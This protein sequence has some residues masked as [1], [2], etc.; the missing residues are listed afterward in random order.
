[1]NHKE[2]ITGSIRYYKVLMAD[3][4]DDMIDKS[5][6]TSAIYIKKTTDEVWGCLPFETKNIP[7]SMLSYTAMNRAAWETEYASGWEL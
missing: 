4:T 3:I 5:T 1:M 6:Y 2:H 7:V